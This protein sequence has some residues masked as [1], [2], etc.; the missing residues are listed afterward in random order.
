V[1]RPGRLTERLRQP[2]ERG[3]SN[4]EPDYNT[5]YPPAVNYTPLYYLINGTAFDKTERHCLAVRGGASQRSH[6]HGAG[7]PRQCRPADARASI[8]GA[9]SGTAVAPALPPSGFSLIAEDGKCCRA[10]ARAE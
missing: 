2:G 10:C 7:A 6:R 5:C 4:A 9:Q 3:R 1:V 8:V